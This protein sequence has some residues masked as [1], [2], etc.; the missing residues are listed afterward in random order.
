MVLLDV[1]LGVN[2]VVLVF[3]QVSITTKLTTQIRYN[4]SNLL[5]FLLSSISLSTI[6][7]IF[8]QFIVTVF[9]DG[10]VYQKVLSPQTNNS[11]IPYGLLSWEWGFPAN[12][13]HY[14]GLYPRSWTIYEIPEVDLVLICEQVISLLF[15]LIK[16]Q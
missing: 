2:S 15:C 13:G 16:I 4:L 1:D 9:R 5:L 10:Q 11:N 14:V 3:V 7:Y 12:H 6:L 8:I